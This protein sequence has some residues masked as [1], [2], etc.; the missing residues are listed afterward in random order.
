LTAAQAQP[1]EGVNVVKEV[2]A[3]APGGLYV[4]NREPLAP[5][6]LLKLPIGSIRPR[7][8]L[9]HQLEAEAAGM[10]GRLAEVSPWCKF[11]G[12]AW[13]DPQGKGHSG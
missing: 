13:T 11:E 9:R 1:S 4:G 7:G 10:T 12:N 8:W 2:K 6:G 5:T 3:D